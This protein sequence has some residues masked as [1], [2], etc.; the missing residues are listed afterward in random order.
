MTNRVCLHCKWWDIKRPH[1]KGDINHCNHDQMD[2]SVLIDNKGA[3]GDGY[4]GIW[5]AQRFGCVNWEGKA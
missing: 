5:T 3:I 1:T 2:G 4:T